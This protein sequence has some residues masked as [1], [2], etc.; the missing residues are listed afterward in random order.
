M[1]FQKKREERA[2]KMKKSEKSH[3]HFVPPT[4]LFS[5][6]AFQSSG[7]QSLSVVGNT[8]KSTDPH[9]WHCISLQTSLVYPSHYQLIHL[10][11]SFVMDP[12]ERLNSV[13]ALTYM[14]VAFERMVAQWCKRALEGLVRLFFLLKKE[15]AATVDH[16]AFVNQS[17]Q[18]ESHAR[19]Y[20]LLDLVFY[21]NHHMLLFFYY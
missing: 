18:D 4:S 20:K 21:H 2:P 5:P 7:S 14:H 9:L 11:S 3:L 12:I 6:L 10:L 15:T 8:Y 16:V 17:K 13:F 19:S 1:A